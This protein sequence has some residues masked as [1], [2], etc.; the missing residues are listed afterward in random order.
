[1]QPLFSIIVPCYNLAPWIRQCL[2]SV[3]EQDCQDWE[4]VV[5]DDES[6][7]GSGDILDE[8]AT[9]DRRFKIIHQKN[10]G[11]GGARNAGLAEAKG[12]WIFFLDGDDV[13]SCSALET[14]SKIVDR[15]PNERLIRFA[16]ENFEDGSALPCVQHQGE[17]KGPIDISKSISYKDY[18]VYVWQFLFKR[19]LIA[20]MKFDRYVR[21][22]DRTFIVPVLCFRANSFVSTEDICYFY[23]KRAGSAIN[24]HASVQALK[25]ELSHHVDVI[26]AIDESGKAMSYRGSSWLEDYCLRRYLNIAEKL[27]GYSRK[28]QHILVEWFYH[29]LPR[30]CRAKDFSFAGKMSVCFYRIFRSR[31]GRYLISWFIPLWVRRMKR[32]IG[33]MFGEQ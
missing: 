31:F 27:G 11:E 29:E 32:V 26:E 3:L 10:A 4:C 6:N 15:Y 33:M 28:E 17:V 8:Y 21:G 5:V 9:K 30:I 25:D 24:S 7:D 13:M 18:F 14:L 20:G 2:D 22:A 12:D 23:R 1:M 19:E 16:Y